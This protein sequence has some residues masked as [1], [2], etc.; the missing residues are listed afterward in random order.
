[1]FNLIHELRQYAGA[2]ALVLGAGLALAY[3][4]IVL[5]IIFCAA[6]LVMR[7]IEEKHR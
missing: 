2:W 4:R 5:A 7:R 3:D 1:M 6:A